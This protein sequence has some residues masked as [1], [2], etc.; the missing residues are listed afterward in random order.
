MRVKHFNITNV[1]SEVATFQFEYIIV[2]DYRGE[3][4]DVAADL[5]PSNRSYSI[6]T[7]DSGVRRAEIN[8]KIEMESIGSQGAVD[9]EISNID[10]DSWVLR[11]VVSSNTEID[12][13]FILPSKAGDVSYIETVLLSTVCYADVDVPFLLD[14]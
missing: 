6:P 4:K 3:V 10:G 2:K 9:L 5:T 12:C 7:E 8:G 11:T 1:T 13:V 14:T